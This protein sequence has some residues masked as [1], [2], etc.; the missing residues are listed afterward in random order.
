[1]FFLVR[2]KWF[3]LRSFSQEDGDGRDQERHRAGHGKNQKPAS[4]EG[5]EGATERGG[6]PLQSPWPGKPFSGNRLS[7][8]GSG[9]GAGPV[10]SGTA[11]P[12]GE[13][14]AAIFCGGDPSG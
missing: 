13:T 11:G 5:G 4:L 1:M 8:P 10:R 2:S 6:D 9:K 7:L 3:D 12:H 14:H